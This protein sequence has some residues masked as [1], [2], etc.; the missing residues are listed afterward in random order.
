M[1]ADINV[2]GILYNLDV[3]I[4]LSKGRGREGVLD[5]RSGHPV[6]KRA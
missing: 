6:R 2:Q 1:R 4:T 3:P 5:M